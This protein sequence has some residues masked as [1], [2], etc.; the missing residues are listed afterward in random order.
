MTD[1]FLDFAALAMLRCLQTAC[2]PL[3]CAPV[4]TSS[5]GRS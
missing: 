5:I 3:G 2:R 1:R 4:S